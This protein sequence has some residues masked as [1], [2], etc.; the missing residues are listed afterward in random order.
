M[1]VSPTA[2]TM[3]IKWRR[4]GSLGRRGECTSNQNNTNLLKT[5]RESLCAACF[6]KF[7]NSVIVFRLPSAE[8]GRGCADLDF[9]VFCYFVCLF[10]PFL[11]HGFACFGCMP[12][13]KQIP[14][15]SPLKAHVDAR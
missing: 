13:E 12:G 11:C 1:C 6:G 9:F 7:G 10:S 5:L 3:W 14:G 15:W 8:G 2:A 4:P